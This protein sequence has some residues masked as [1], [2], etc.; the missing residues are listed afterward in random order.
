MYMIMAFV[1]YFCVLTSIGICFYR[2]NKNASDYIIGNR[3]INY[4]VTAIAT[5]ASDMGIWLFMGFPA[6]VYA[7]GLFESW[8]AIG[9]T[10]C[11]FLNWQFIAPRLRYQTEQYNALT[12][13]TYFSKR[14]N[15]TNGIL[16]IIS[17]LI[18]VWFFTAYISSALVGM[19][20]LFNNAFSI[21]YHYGTLIGLI[22]GLTYTLIGGFI[23]VAWGDL[24]QGIFLLIMIM[25]VPACTYVYVGGA[26]AIGTAATLKGVSLSLLNSE[27]SIISALLL[28]ASWGL[29]YFGQ[30]HILINFMGIDNP[31][32]ISSAKWVGISWQ[33]LVL[34]AATLIGVTGLAFNT[35]QITQPEDLFIIITKTLFPSLLAGF[36]LCAILAATL[37]TMD[38]H[39]LISGSTFAQDIYKMIKGKHVDSHTLMHASRIA[40]IAISLIALYIASF[41][42]SSVYNL[43]NYAWS[44][45]GSA[46]GPLVITALYS[47][48][49]TRTAAL[50]G[51]IVGALVSGIWPWITTTTILPLVPGFCAGLVTLYVVSWISKRIHPQHTN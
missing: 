46:F 17:A 36:V 45:T 23:A 19:G 41:N 7:N 27:H 37:S 50:A 44:G 39:I 9:L 16:R 12:L 22:S 11:M 26:S 25:L 13:S 38:S 42:N 47:N 8:T 4:V 10:T 34:T 14:F 24:F 48:Y 15:D 28:A 18:T 2:K 40:S 49:I 5:Q 21:D 30:P 31:K 3:S 32:K 29:G 51:M 1:I 43:V 20:R 6:A 33:I 35:T